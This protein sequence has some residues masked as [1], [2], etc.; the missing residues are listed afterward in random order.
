MMQIAKHVYDS[1]SDNIFEMYAYAQSY[2]ARRQIVM[3]WRGDYEYPI[4]QFTD[5]SIIA[6]TLYQ[7]HPVAAKRM[8]KQAYDERNLI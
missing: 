3:V 5:G 1:C 6:F 7:G 4:M 8:K 2:G